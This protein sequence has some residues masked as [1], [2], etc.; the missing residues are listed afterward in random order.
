MDKQELTVTVELDE[1]LQKACEPFD[2]HF[3]GTS[4]FRLPTFAPRPRDGTWSIGLIIGPSGSGKSQLLRKHYGETAEPKWNRDKAIVSHFPDYATAMARLAA[5]GLSSVPAWCRP[6]H[7]LS[8]GEQFRARLARM[9]DNNTSF[10]EFT[11][12]VDRTVAKACCHAMQREIRRAKLTG[13]VFCS[14]H[15]DIVEWLQPDWTFDTLTSESLERGQLH[16]RPSIELVIRPCNRSWWRVFQD[17]HYMSS[18][19]NVCAH[20]WLA[21]WNKQPVAFASAIA[22][23]SGHGMNLWREHRTVTLPDYQGLGIGVRVSDAV[24]QMHLDHGMKYYSKT[25]H[26]RMGEYRNH[27]PLWRATGDNLLNRGD[28]DGGAA[29]FWA[30]KT[31]TNR[32][33]YSH[34]Y[35]GPTGKPPE[36]VKNL[37]PSK[38]KRQAKIARMA[39]KDKAEKAQ[40][41]LF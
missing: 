2:Y 16:R 26:P 24:A 9:L 25:A 32:A 20:T 4:R 31:R 19:L 5:V 27:S 15:R 11:S 21:E 3:D 33:C 34:E 29:E 41:R 36:A 10:D 38:S 12:V 37:G 28:D 8:N 35:I 30:W 14:C 7:V 13:I 17:H 18:D 22:F 6:Y 1:I 23:P 39:A 40:E